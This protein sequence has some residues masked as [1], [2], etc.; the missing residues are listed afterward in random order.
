MGFYDS[1]WYNGGNKTKQERKCKYRILRRYGFNP[2]QA[3]ADRDIHTTQLIRQHF[4]NKALCFE[5]A[6]TL[7][8]R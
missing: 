7:N 4:D 2:E 5:L 8:L 3:Q 1:N 6:L